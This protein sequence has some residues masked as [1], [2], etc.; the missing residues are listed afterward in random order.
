M[1]PTFQ[2]IV[3]SSKRVGQPLRIIEPPGVPSADDVAAVL[4]TVERRVGRLIDV[5]Y[6][7]R[8]QI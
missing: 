8:S 4:A 1:V 5:N 6:F 7:C 3:I 2:S